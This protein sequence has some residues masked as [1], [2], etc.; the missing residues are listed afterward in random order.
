MSDRERER[1]KRAE[2][3][4]DRKATLSEVVFLMTLSISSVHPAPS[5]RNEVMFG[6]QG[7]EAAFPTLPVGRGSP[8]KHHSVRLQMDR[9]GTTLPEELI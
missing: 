8:D 5:M 2:R 6:V 7:E 3:H 1:E 9:K 4:R